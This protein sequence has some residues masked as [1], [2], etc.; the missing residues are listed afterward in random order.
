MGLQGRPEASTFLLDRYFFVH[1]R[2]MSVKKNST[3]GA[4]AN[5]KKAARGAATKRTSAAAMMESLFACKWSARIMTLIRHGT[6]RPGAITRA[7]DGLTA[8]VMNDCLRRMM[9]FGLVERQAYAEIP[10]R[11]EYHLTELGQ[12]VVAI[13]DAVE[14]L[15]PEIAARFDNAQ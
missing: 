7:L 9:A 6:A 5:G 14:A 11:V 13:I 10:P 12:R 2:D 1:F 3:T 4:A 8:K 15:Q